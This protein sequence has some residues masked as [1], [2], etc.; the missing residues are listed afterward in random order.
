[1]SKSSARSKSLDYSL[2]A[3]IAIIVVTG[4][5]ILSSVSAAF[6]FKRY[7][8]T[9]YFLK[10]QIIFGLLPGLVLGFLAY[11][12]KLSFFKKWSGPFILLALIMMIMVFLP[13]VGSSS[14]DAA[15]WIRIGSFSFQPSE[16][17]KLAF[18]IYL[19]AWL[20][21]RLEKIKQNK[22]ASFWGTFL[23]FLMVL[24]VIIVLL[25]CQSNASTLG[26]IVAVGII[27]YF[28]TNTPVFHTFITILLGGGGLFLIVKAAPYRVSRWMVF[29]NPDL[30]PMGKGYQLQQALIAVGSGGVGG[31]GLGMSAQKFGFLPQT[32][33][34]SIFAVFA[35][36]TGF[37]GAVILIFLFLIF[38]W[39]AL[40]T[41]K[42]SQDNFS[43]LLAL[44][45][46]S[47]IIIQTFV[48]IGAMIGIL[49]LTGIPL[50]FVS[51]GGSALGMELV[52]MGLLLNISKNST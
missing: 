16:A 34:D 7:G 9:Y 14:G 37:I 21:N 6:A 47:W 38:L 36:E 1:M 29:L 2:L 32:V 18:V 28:S 52:G 17:L 31:T 22:E 40:N 12:I 20:S 42:E 26:V 50:P 44:G 27:M 41:A 43:R 19:A 13:G 33:S 3:I 15:R 11:K 30:D 48:N 10:H 4:I 39:R 25:F 49:P 24:G 23:S 8:D 35:E 46:T 5:L 45:I 51:Y